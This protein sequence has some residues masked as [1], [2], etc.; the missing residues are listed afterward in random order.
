MAAVYDV[1]DRLIHSSDFKVENVEFAGPEV[2]SSA[3]EC[4]KCDGK[5]CSYDGLA[6]CCETGDE[7][8]SPGCN[9]I[10]DV[11]DKVN[12]G[13]SIQCGNTDFDFS[14]TIGKKV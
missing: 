2:M 13:S 3:D 12:C 9:C 6:W 11:F 5:V 7:K 1:I 10:G 8:N 4:I 14:K